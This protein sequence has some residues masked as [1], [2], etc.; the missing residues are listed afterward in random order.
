VK[1][2]L[3]PPRHYLQRRGNLNCGADFARARLTIRSLFAGYCRAIPYQRGRD[4]R[5]KAFAA[6]RRIPHY[7]LLRRK[8]SRASPSKK[9][10]EHILFRLRRII[11]VIEGP[12][13]LSARRRLSTTVEDHQFVQKSAGL[14]DTAPTIKTLPS[15]P[16]SL[17]QHWGMT[18][19]FAIPAPVCPRLWS[20]HA[21]R[22]KCP[23]FASWGT[24]MAGRCTG[25]GSNRYFAIEHLRPGQASF[26]KSRDGP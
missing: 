18:I 24:P 26:R 25:C 22:R 23:V 7:I 5:F 2:T 16:V 12:R 17:A 15:C 9:L 6:H 11:S 4:Q 19:D 20:L 8:R 13:G 3:K 14:D 21:R 1:V 10:A